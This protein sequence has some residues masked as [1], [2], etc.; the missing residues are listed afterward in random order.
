[1]TGRINSARHEQESQ[2]LPH[3][4]TAASYHRFRAACLDTG[5][6]DQT[7]AARWR[8][9]H[10]S[11]GI[12]ERELGDIFRMEAIHVLRGLKKTKTAPEREP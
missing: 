10:K 8:A 12:F 3:N 4:H 5:G 11:R 9:E 1:M 7:H 6:F 2:R